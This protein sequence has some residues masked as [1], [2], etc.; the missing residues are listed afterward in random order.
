[1]LS[2]KEYY[3]RMKIRGLDKNKPLNNQCKL[4]SNTDN[5][6]KHHTNYQLREYI[7]I[8]KNCHYKLH[9]ELRQL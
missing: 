4:C 7:T 9:K 1:M 8:C 6:E 5:L 3:F 2:D